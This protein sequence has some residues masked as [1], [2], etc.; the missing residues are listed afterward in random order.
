[1]TTKAKAKGERMTTKAKAAAKRKP[2]H[3]YNNKQTITLE[4]A[5]IARAAT[6][7]DDTGL[8]LHEVHKASLRF[9]IDHFSKKP[10]DLVTFRIKLLKESKRKAGKK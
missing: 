4:D 3:T 5:D 10:L 9:G 2:P 8:N 7:V 6:L 1:M